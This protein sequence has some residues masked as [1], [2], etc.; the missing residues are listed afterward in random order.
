MPIPFTQYLRP[1]GRRTPV[2]IDM[3]PEIETLAEEVIEL[4]GRFECE[5]LMT[6]HA[7]LTVAYRL[8][9]EEQ[10]IAIEVVPNGPEVPDAV[11]RLVK[12][13]HAK[14]LS[15]KGASHDQT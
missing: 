5:H 15:Y 3:P 13:A 10:D 14:L 6:G 12:A 9:G 11:G 1:D 8:N 2:E 4:G 7:S